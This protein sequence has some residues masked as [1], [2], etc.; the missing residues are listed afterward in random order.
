MV[1]DTV[2]FTLGTSYAY[3]VVHNDVE[4]DK[5]NWRKI[6]AEAIAKELVEGPY[7]QTST[8]YLIEQDAYHTTFVVVLGRKKMKLPA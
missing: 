4:H 2:E 7:L 3:D 8:R 5:K 6:A 1:K